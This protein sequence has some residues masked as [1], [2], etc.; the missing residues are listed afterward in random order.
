VLSTIG[1]LPGAM[2]VPVVVTADVGTGN[3][4]YTLPY[5]G[6]Y[7][8]V[9]KSGAIQVRGTDYTRTG[10]QITFVAGNIPLSTSKVTISV[11][12]AATDLGAM[13]VPAI[14]AADAGT[15]NATYTLPTTGGYE[16]V[17][18]SGA[19]QVR[20]TD[21][22]RT[23]TKITF[24]AGNI[25]L[26]T[27]KVVI[28]CSIS[29]NDIDAITLQGSAPAVTST[30][31]AIVKTTAGGVIDSTMLPDMGTY[32]ETGTLEEDQTLNADGTLATV[33]WKNGATTVKTLTIT[34]N[35]D[36]SIATKVY[37]A[38]GKTATHTYAYGSGTV[39]VTKVVV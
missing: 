27:A 11:S 2:S 34:Y 15:G 24:V 10:N 32:M 20:G 3:A 23:G 33:T 16:M 7:E 36:G 6:N 4:T 29:D 19:I 1:N 25:P 30:A 18:K 28:S 31:N 21:Y 39:T 38:N 5:L 9:W 17:W 12:V 13:S 14:V 37:V 26:S 8:M 22:T 35:S